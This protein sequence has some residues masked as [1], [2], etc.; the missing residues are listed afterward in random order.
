MC[1]ALYGAGASRRL[2]QPVLSLL[3]FTR[4]AF[5]LPVHAAYAT[6]IQ[7]QIDLLDEYDYIVVG[8]GTAG[9]TVADRLSENGDCGFKDS[10]TIHPIKRTNIEARHSTGD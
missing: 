9:L 7:R 8:G 6:V 5:S 3:V 1:S 10:A 2:L 4:L